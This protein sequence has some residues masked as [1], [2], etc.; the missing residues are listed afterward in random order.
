MSNQLQ[1]VDAPQAPA[2]VKRQSFLELE[3]AA[4]IERA[5]HIATLLRDVVTKQSLYQNIQGNDYLKVE[6]WTTLGMMLGV[7]AREV[8]S[9]R[10]PNGSWEAR[11]ELVALGTGQVIGAASALCSPDEAR[12]RKAEEFARRS[13]AITR[14]TGKAFRLVF[15]WIVTLAGYQPTP[16]EEM[17]YERESAPVEQPSA[18]RDLDLFDRELMQHRQWFEQQMTKYK[19]RNDVWSDI[20][21]ELQGKPRTDLTKAAQAV[22]NKR[23]KAQ[24]A[25]AVV[26]EPEI[27]DAELLAGVFET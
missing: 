23:K 7:T 6:G 16:A 27:V 9:K 11:V 18:T 10:L 3:P 22:S 20:A 21:T 8:D 24:A 1:K 13:M 5:A 4:M 26:I 2:V 25:P 19:I 17:E 15:S 12:W 14:A